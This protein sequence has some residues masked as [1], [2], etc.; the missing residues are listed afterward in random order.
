[1]RGYGRCLILNFGRS[2]PLRD[3]APSRK[4]GIDQA[5]LVA[6]A[7]SQPPGAALP[8]LVPGECLGPDQHFAIA[9]NLNPSD[10]ILGGALPSESPQ[11]AVRCVSAPDRVIPFAGTCSPRSL[12]FPTSSTRAVPIGR[13]RPRRIPRRAVSI[14]RRFHSCRII[15]TNRARP[16]R[17]T[18]R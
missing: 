4:R 18:S 9:K 5:A 14:S 15:L 16:S 10:L 2:I 7:G 3:F 13:A 12:P 11:S 6:A 8:S 17:Q 1:M